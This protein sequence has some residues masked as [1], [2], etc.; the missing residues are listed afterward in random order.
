M[1]KGVTKF[2]RSITAVNQVSEIFHQ[3]LAESTSGR[4]GP[5]LIDIPIN[6]Q[7][8]EITTNRISN[9]INDHKEPKDFTEILTLISNSKRPL[10]LAGGGIRI[11]N[12]TTSFLKFVEKFQIPVVTSLMGIDSISSESKYKIGM[13]G[14]YGNRWANRAMLHSDLLLVLGSRLDIRQTGA[15]VESFSRNKVIIRIDIDES[16]IGGRV[17]SNVAYISSLNAFFD[18]MGK[19]DYLSDRAHLDIL[20]EAEK[21]AKENKQEKN[22]IS[23]IPELR[24]RMPMKLIA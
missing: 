7:Q 19:A 15:D 4:P 21:F 3:A 18:F 1:S 17:E 24:M 14:S 20:G 22:P 12:A 13:I 16:E 5:V 10:I 8:Q 11:A 2:S 9:P 6:I 23:C